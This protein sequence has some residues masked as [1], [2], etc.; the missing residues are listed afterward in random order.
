VL[1]VQPALGDVGHASEPVQILGLE[2]QEPVLAGQSPAG[3]DLFPDRQE[4]TVAEQGRRDH[5]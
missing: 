5:G 4:A 1:A 3:L 2:E